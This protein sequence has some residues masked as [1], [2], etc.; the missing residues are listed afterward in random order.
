MKSLYPSG[1]LSLRV[2]PHRQQR[3]DRDW[4]ADRDGSQSRPA[5]VAQRLAV[6]AAVSG[7]CTTHIMGP[8]MR[9]KGF[10]VLLVLVIIR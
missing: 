6:P 7:V 9:E 1:T 2:D 4:E 10:G 3:V 8:D 5:A